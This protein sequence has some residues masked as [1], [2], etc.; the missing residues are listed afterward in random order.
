VNARLWEWHGALD[1]SG[2]RRD[3]RGRP[4]YLIC[5]RQQGTAPWRR[6]TL[7]TASGSPPT[8]TEVLRAIEEVER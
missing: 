5:Y 2:G 6:F 4:A 1:A 3:A 7:S 8:E